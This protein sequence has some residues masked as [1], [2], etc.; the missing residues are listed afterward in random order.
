MWIHFLFTL[1]LWL[2]AWKVS[3]VMISTNVNPLSLPSAVNIWRKTKHWFA[4]SSSMKAQS[5]EHIERLVFW[6]WFNPQHGQREN[7]CTDWCQAQY[8]QGISGTHPGCLASSLRG[9]F[10]CCVSS[11]STSPG[12]REE[13][14]GNQVR[15]WKHPHRPQATFQ[16]CSMKS[17]CAGSDKGNIFLTFSCNTFEANWKLVTCP[18]HTHSCCQCKKGHCAVL[19]GQLAS[20]TDRPPYHAG[21]IRLSWRAN[22]VCLYAEVELF[23]RNLAWGKKAVSPIWEVK[24]LD[25]TVR[26][27]TKHFGKTR[28][29]G[30]KGPGSEH[31]PQHQL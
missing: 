22:L 24:S 28:Y 19:R 26:V 4:Q 10:S 27:T 6:L 5:K 30:D 25:A 7:I 9:H 1:F 8:L 29:K 13:V 17:G 14:W 3:I 15:W 20:N 18:C 31:M 21:V 12:L 11:D 23:P 16:G 2:L